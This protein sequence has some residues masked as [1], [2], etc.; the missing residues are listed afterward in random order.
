MVAGNS[1]NVDIQADVVSGL[2][3]RVSRT[4]KGG[5]MN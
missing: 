2:R 1:E 5:E 4:L 3:L